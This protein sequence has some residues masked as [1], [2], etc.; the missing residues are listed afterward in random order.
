MS[1][2]TDNVNGKD[3]ELLYNNNYIMDVKKIDKSND[4]FAIKTFDA[5][6]DK[7][8]PITVDEN[9]AITI[10]NINSRGKYYSNEPPN[11]IIKPPASSGGT[12]A[13]ARA[14]M[15]EKAGAG[16]NENSYWEIKDII[17]DYR[18]SKYDAIADID[19][20]EIEKKNTVQKKIVYN[21]AKP[22][23]YLLEKKQSQC[24][25]LT[26]RWH[27]WFT[28]PYYYLGNNNGRR[29]IDESDK[30][31]KIFKCYNSC[32]EKHVVNN[33][34]VCE[35]IQTFEG[36]KYRNYIPYDPLAIICILG[37]YEATGKLTENNN[38]I[39]PETVAGNYYDTIK[40][41]KTDNDEDINKE[42]QA[43]ILAS[44]GNIEYR[45][46]NNEHPVQ[47]IGEGIG[48][49][50]TVISQYIKDIIR[51]AE[52]NDLKIKTTIKNNVN[53]F[54]QLFDKRDE[55]YI[56]YLNK[57]KDS[58][59]F[60]RVLYAKSIA[61]KVT[62]AT[63]YNIDNDATKKYLQYLFKYCKFLYFN[64]NNMFAIRLLNY[65]IYDED[66]I[67]D[68]KVKIINPDEDETYLNVVPPEPV[69]VNYNPVTVKI[70]NKH[71]NIFDD[72]S[73][74]YEL[75]KSFILT[76]PIILLLSIGLFIIIMLLYW[77][78]VIYVLISALNFLYILV[79]A[80]VYFFIV[81][82]ACNSLFIKIIVSIISGI[83]QV[84]GGLYSGIM[85]IFNFPIIGTIIK[86]VLFLILIGI[87][88]NNN[89]GFIYDIVMFFI[90]TIIYIIL[91]IISI[92][93]YIIYE[94]IKLNPGI[95]F[96]SLITMLILYAYYKI[97][98]N[99]DINTLHKDAKKDAKIISEHSNSETIFK[100][101]VLK[102][103]VGAAISMARL[104]LYKHSYFMNLYEKAYD[105]YVE[106]IEELEGYKNNEKLLE[107]SNMTESE[108]AEEEKEKKSAEITNLQN[109]N[110]EF[111]KKVDKANIARAERREV[112]KK[113][114]D[115]DIKNDKTIKDTNME[116]YKNKLGKSKLNPEQIEDI[117]NE[118]KKILDN[119]KDLLKQVRELKTSENKA[120][121][122]IKPFISKNVQKNID[123]KK[124]TLSKGFSSILG[125]NQVNAINK[126]G[127]M[128]MGVDKAK[129]MFDKIKIDPLAL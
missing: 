125:E 117:K 102:S 65:G 22:K 16:P 10:I 107:P 74:A 75:Y 62:D 87:L 58:T 120:R 57:L 67:K 93:F 40:N 44:L 23:Y 95:L 99:F 42:V 4:L 54:Y 118:R 116:L 108:K 3:L 113:L 25:N 43:K 17:V 13:R 121:G 2:C 52:N 73:N 127:L 124:D 39:I 18:G 19:K 37:S 94:C 6:L 5:E 97:W 34:N 91:G 82:I 111:E 81:L 129:G 79:I 14:T 30:T 21:E 8:R 104:E 59:H 122:D 71:K 123:K 66:Y 32:A 96:P 88:M 31:R 72:Y 105:N 45:Y 110:V 35:N 29:K 89:L 92:V 114:M 86:F 90:N 12:P 109:K 69:K 60:K 63:P 28:I 51:E 77:K 1:K 100:S 78:N 101:G 68:T 103:G 112:E 26:D 80:I 126:Q 9:G 83:Y 115:F 84:I 38:T 41:V 7:S 27:D 47:I 61:H 70:E 33:D 53:D 106:K 36:G 11:I 98:F 24:N 48:K 46:R 15:D 20:V 76:Y 49:A 85:G 56:S 128:N 119:K 50:Y 55:L 64:E